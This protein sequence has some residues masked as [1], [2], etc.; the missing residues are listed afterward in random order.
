MQQAISGQHAAYYGFP[1][2]PEC[3]HIFK[4]RPFCTA[5]QRLR[6]NA[7]QAQRNVTASVPNAVQDSKQSNQSSRS[8]SDNTTPSTDPLMVRAARGE[9]V[10]RPPC[11]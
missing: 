5:P 11:W 1:T 10:D 6:R 9:K 2:M 3:K 7:R 4:P 8:R